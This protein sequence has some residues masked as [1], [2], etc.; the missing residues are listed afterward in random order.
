MHISTY[1]AYGILSKEVVKCIH[2]V[3]IAPSFYTIK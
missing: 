2:I 1:I 3:E